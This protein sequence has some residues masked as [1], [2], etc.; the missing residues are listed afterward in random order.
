MK[1]ILTIIL[2]LVAILYIIIYALCR[3]ASDDDAERE[4]MAREWDKDK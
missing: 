1:L 3:A 2:P 4:R